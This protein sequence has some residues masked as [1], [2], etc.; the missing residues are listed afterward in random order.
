MEKNPMLQEVIAAFGF[1]G[2]L[3]ECIPFGSGHINDTYRLTYLV[4]EAAQKRYI[5]QK[6]NKEVFTKPVELMENISGVTSW[7]KKKIQENGGDIER[8][9]LNIV[10]TS[11]GQAYYV[12]SC[13]EY[14][15]SYL[16][17]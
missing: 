9:T 1:Q 2:S 8:E 14:W 11:D 5:L 13:G 16:F 10:Y 4:E 7:L 6:M 15:R 3:E 12:D 17:I